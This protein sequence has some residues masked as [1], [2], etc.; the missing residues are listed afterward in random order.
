M[1]PMEFALSLINTFNKDVPSSNHMGSIMLVTLG[2]TN[3]NNILA[4]Y[5]E[6]IRKTGIISNCC[7]CKKEYLIRK[8]KTLLLKLYSAYE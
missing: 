8:K 3:I 7:K 2:E 4:L 1:T 6:N 5:L